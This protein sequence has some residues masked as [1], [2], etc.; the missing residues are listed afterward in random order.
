VLGRALLH[1][2]SYDLAIA[3]ARRSVELNPNSGT[4]LGGLG[5]V[6]AYAGDAE[7]AI[8]VGERGFQLSPPEPY[9]A[10][11]IWYAGIAACRLQ[12]F[13]TALRHSET[14]ILVKPD[15]ATGHLLRAV[16]C[17]GLARSSDATASVQEARKWTESLSLGRI[18]NYMPYRRVAD[19][20]NTIKKLREAGLPNE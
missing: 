2:G 7:E 13:E 12:Q 5:G 6:L 19:L 9:T 11:W 4:S 17:C 8:A 14:G 16:A 1:S 3:A 10:L 18:P 20:E 15:V